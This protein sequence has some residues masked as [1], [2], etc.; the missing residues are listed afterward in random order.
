MCPTP[1]HPR[2]PCVRSHPNT[3]GPATPRHPISHTALL[4]RAKPYPRG[5]GPAA[6]VLDLEVRSLISLLVTPS[7]HDLGGPVRPTSTRP[8]AH[9]PSPTAHPPTHLHYPPPRL[10]YP[11]IRPL[12]PP[13][14]P[15]L[16]T[17]HTHPRPPAAR[18]DPPGALEPGP[19][20]QRAPAELLER[21]GHNQ[22]PDLV[23]PPSRVN[24]HLHSGAEWDPAGQ[25]NKDPQ[26]PQDPTGPGGNPQE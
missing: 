19:L 12:N 6:S 2:P 18:L 8:P 23:E 3:T 24:T 17:R 20:P 22:R 15:A 7:L 4:A 14:P 11:P 5:P 13:S 25:R 16:T 9:P 1:P 26:D 21:T 10:H